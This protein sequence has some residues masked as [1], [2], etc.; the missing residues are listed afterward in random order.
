MSENLNE[1]QQNVEPAPKKKKSKKWLIFVII[2]V[3]IIIIIAAASGSGSD[4]ATST[5][6]K[7]SAALEAEKGSTDENTLGD[8]K[9]VVKGA[10]L[11]KD[12]LGKDAVI[13]TYEF[14]NNSD[15]PASFD[16]ALDDNVYQDGIGLE[17]GIL[18]GDA[19]QDLFDVEIKTGVTKEVK[20]V[21]VLRDTTT[22]LDIEV[23]ELL[24]WDDA[25]ITT[26]VKIEK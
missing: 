17:T 25:K 18:G 13:I 23:S 10:K 24:S 2:A 9:C 26:T 12:Y 11:T 22:D 20:K 8:Y 1:N 5:T 19:D 4:D 21:Y 14:T 15:S 3:V 7:Q 16:V 6:T